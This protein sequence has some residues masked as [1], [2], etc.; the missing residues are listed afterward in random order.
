MTLAADTCSTLRRYRLVHACNADAADLPR[1][2]DMLGQPRDFGS[3]RGD[4]EQVDLNRI[5]GVHRDVLLISYKWRGR[6]QA[7]HHWRVRD[8]AGDQRRQRCSDV[9]R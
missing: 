9:T 7:E 6:S 2:A 4:T 8:V 3:C 1:T 5:L